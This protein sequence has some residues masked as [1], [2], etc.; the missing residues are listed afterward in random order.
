M[1]MFSL[2]TIFV[3][4]RALFASSIL[5]GDAKFQYYVLQKS[6]ETYFCLK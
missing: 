4:F 3:L 1:P 2:A 6:L 5:S